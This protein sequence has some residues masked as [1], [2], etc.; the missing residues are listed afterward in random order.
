MPSLTGMKPDGF[1]D[2]H[3]SLQRSSQALFAG[4]VRDAIASMALPDEPALLAVADYGCSEGRNSIEAVGVVVEAWRRRRPAQP[5]C[6]IHNDLPGNNFNQLF[7]RL[8]AP[9]ASNYLQANGKREPNVFAL[10]AAGSFYEPLLPP[11]S[12]HIAL[13][14]FGIQWMDRRPDVVV[15]DFIGYMRGAAEAQAAFARQADHD[16]TR[17]LQ[18]RADELAP[19]GKLL[20]AVPGKH[21]KRSCSDGL[22]DMFDDACKDLV[23]A[24]VLDRACYERFLFPVYFRSL[25][26][27][28]APLNCPG[29]LLGG[30]FVVDRAEAMDWPPPFSTEFARTGDAAAYADAFVGSIRAWSEP[31]CAAE[32]VPP[33][34]R[35]AGVLEALYKRAHERVV[36]QPERYPYSNLVVAMLLTRK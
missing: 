36:A 25:D 23:A 4:W 24:G 20:V 29:T 13:S 21:G 15:P 28:L 30:A 10:A 31:I 8:H 9:D 32:L 12:V 17:F 35:A 11:G 16:L 2:D 19:G 34:E 33:G 5:I 22:Y 6:A 18:C 1:Y 26:E 14:N 3:S 7:T 27:M